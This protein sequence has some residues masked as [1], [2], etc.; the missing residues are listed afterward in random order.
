MSKILFNYYQL[1]N[2]NNVPNADFE[3]CQMMIL[4]CI[5]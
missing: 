5:K 4:E 2:F 1:I 3:M